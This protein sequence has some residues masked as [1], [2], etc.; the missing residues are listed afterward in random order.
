MTRD[1][2]RQYVIDNPMQWPPLTDA[3]RLQLAVILRPDVT[4]SP[5][6]LR[7]GAEPSEA[8]SPTATQRGARRGPQRHAHGR[9]DDP[10]RSSDG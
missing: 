4:P 7:V 2:I 10:G 9:Q 6:R 3:Q 1:E 5:T 8:P